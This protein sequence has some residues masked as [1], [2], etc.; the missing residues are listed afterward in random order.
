EDTVMVADMGRE[1][2]TVMVADTDRVEDT[3]TE[4]D[5]DMVADTVTVDMVTTHLRKRRKIRNKRL[6]S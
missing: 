2:D 3:D 4:A 6:K 1:E 5:T